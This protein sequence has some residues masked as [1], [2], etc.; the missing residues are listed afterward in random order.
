MRGLS[1]P[2][3]ANGSRMSTTQAPAWKMNMIVVLL[4]YPV[5]FLFGLW[6]GTP[7]LI[8]DPGSAI[9]PFAVSRQRRQRRHAELPGARG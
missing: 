3:S 1:A 6:V 7:I 8:E 2:A 5:V 9:L 4:L